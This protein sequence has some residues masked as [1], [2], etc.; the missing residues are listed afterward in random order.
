MLGALGLL[1]LAPSDL[2]CREGQGR[3]MLLGVGGLLSLRRRVP[4]LAH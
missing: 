3:P 2:A 1:H 4:R